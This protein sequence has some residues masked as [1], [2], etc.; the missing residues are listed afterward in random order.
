MFCFMGCPLGLLGWCIEYLGIHLLPFPKQAH[1]KHQKC[2]TTNCPYQGGQTK[3]ESI[4]KTYIKQNPFVK[5][6]PAFHV[7]LFMSCFLHWFIYLFT[8]S[9][10]LHDCVVAS[11][12]PLYV[13][14]ACT[15]LVHDFLSSISP[16]VQKQVNEAT[17]LI[18]NQPTP[19]FSGDQI[20][21]KV[22][23]HDMN[24]QISFP[25][26]IGMVHQKVQEYPI[27]QK[28][29]PFYDVYQQTFGF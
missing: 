3:K 13:P 22:I 15:H 19:R 6:P 24:K 28:N 7:F 21:N 5:G 17:T 20:Y 26:W 25:L 1:I 2:K 18:L 14:T 29:V 23:A 10:F 11:V 4:M 12:Q 16:L 9:H 27:R 8:I